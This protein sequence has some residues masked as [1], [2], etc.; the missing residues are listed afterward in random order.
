MR[1]IIVLEAC[2]AS[3]DMAHECA[4]LHGHVYVVGVLTCSSW[5]NSTQSDSAAAEKG[6]AV[7]VRGRKRWQSGRKRK[8]HGLG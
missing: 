4:L 6:A 2:S 8:G 1:N 3:V 5:G 7:A